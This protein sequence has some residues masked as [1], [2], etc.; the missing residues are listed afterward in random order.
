MSSI[1]PERLQYM[2]LVSNDGYLRELITAY[3][4]EVAAREKAESEREEFRAMLEH[5]VNG[6]IVLDA[7]YYAARALL[8]RLKDGK[9]S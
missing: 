7:E 3:R 4:A 1:T 8:A 6:C 2:L 9:A 5:T